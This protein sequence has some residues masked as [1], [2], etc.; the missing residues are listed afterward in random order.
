M[1]SAHLIHLTDAILKICHLVLT[2]VEAEG[3]LVIEC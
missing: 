2:D 3:R 1:A